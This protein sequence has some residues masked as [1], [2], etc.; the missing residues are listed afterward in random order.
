[1]GLF[2]APIAQVDLFEADTVR[3][4]TALMNS[5]IKDHN[6]CL[7]DIFRFSFRVHANWHLSARLKAG[8]ALWSTA[9]KSKPAHNL[10]GWTDLGEIEAIWESDL[11]CEDVLLDLDI[12]FGETCPPRKGQSFDMHL[13]WARNASL[14]M[15]ARPEMM[16]EARGSEVIGADADSARRREIATILIPAGN[17]QHASL[18]AFTQAKRDF[19]RLVKVWDTLS[20]RGSRFPMMASPSA[21]HV[22][23][24]K[25]NLA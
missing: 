24:L 16:F 3:N 17:S 21:E 12:P 23:A 5:G 2:H 20:V 14:L 7:A 19:Q 1:M 15:Y 9:E 8:V 13:Y 11:I 10:V 6:G 18:K 25:R 4:L 22:Y